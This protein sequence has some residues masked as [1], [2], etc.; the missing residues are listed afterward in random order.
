MVLRRIKG[1]IWGYI[2][3]PPSKIRHISR[4]KEKVGLMK[5]KNADYER[6]FDKALEAEY[7][8]AKILR[9]RVA[10]A[11]LSVLAIYMVGCW[12]RWELIDSLFRGQ[13]L[14]FLFH[15]LLY[16]GVC[17]ILLSVI[18]VFWEK[19]Q[20]CFIGAAMTARDRL[21]E[22]KEAKS[23]ASKVYRGKDQMYNPNKEEAELYKK[24]VLSR[25]AAAEGKA[26]PSGK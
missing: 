18:R 15:T 26:K 6:F 19:D 14:S 3:M 5:K 21:K 20:K 12:I 25:R 22:L 1:F 4:I 17:C 2:L 7:R 8:E 11:V 10:I 9:N 16:L 13:F 23:G 24:Q